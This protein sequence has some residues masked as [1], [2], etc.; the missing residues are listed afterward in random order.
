MEG[1][2][3]KKAL[4]DQFDAAIRNVTLD[5]S[6]VYGKPRDTSTGSAFSPRQREDTNVCFCA[7]RMRLQATGMGAFSPT[8]S[9]EED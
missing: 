4:L 7:S 3:E 5:R 2:A 6:A 1:E 8:A 9:L